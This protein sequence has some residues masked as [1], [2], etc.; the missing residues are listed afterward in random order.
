MKDV[1]CNKTTQKYNVLIKQWMRITDPLEPL[2]QVLKV[3]PWAHHF[4]RSLPI[5]D[6]STLNMCE[7]GTD[8]IAAY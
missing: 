4:Q 6:I 3:L 1:S 5:Q 2:E 7:L 8:D